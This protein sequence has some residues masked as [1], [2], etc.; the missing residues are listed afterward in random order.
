MKKLIFLL[1]ISLYSCTQESSPNEHETT[2]SEDQEVS[3]AA[4]CN[5]L[6]TFYNTL[7]PLSS[8]IKTRSYKDSLMVTGKEQEIISKNVKD[9]D[10]SSLNLLLKLGI[11]EHDILE[12]RI[13]ETPLATTLATLAVV[14]YLDNQQLIETTYPIFLGPEERMVTFEQYKEYSIDCLL[15]LVGL[16]TVALAGAA[17]RNAASKKVI[18]AAIK[19]ILTEFAATAIKYGSKG[20]YGALALV[21]EWGLCM[22]GKLS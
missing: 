7:S 6:N 4:F 18:V 5:S 9:I 17:I 14:S 15:E 10:E 12:T 11:T 16:D 8:E 1:A 13:N 21:V 3:I 20:T 2:L 22:K 19:E